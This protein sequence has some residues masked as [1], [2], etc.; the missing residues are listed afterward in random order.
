MLH[1]IQDAVKQ[2]L[3]S[4]K[5]TS[6]NGW[7]SFNAV[8]C[9]HTGES[10]DTRSRGGLVANAD[11]GVSYH[12]FNCHYKA[13]YTPG[14]HLNFKFR[15]LLQWLG[16][17]DNEVKR[18]V[19][20]ALRIKDFVAPEKV[21]E[22]K[23]EVTFKKRPLPDNSVS[24]REWETFIRLQA[25]DDLLNQQFLSTFNYV[26]DRKIDFGKYDFYTTENE[27]Y[28]LHK[29][30]II[31]FIWQGDIIGYT[32]RAW[33]DK[34]SPKYHNSYE[35]NFVFNTNNQLV[36]SKFVLVTEGPFDAMSVDGVAI[37]GS[38]CSETQADIIESL[39][40]EVIVVPDFD[41]KEVRGK[42]VWAGETLVDKAI[43]YG[44]SVSFPV[45]SEQVKDTAAA[46]EA[47]GKLFTIKSILAGKQSSR[48]KIEL[49]KRRIHTS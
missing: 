7:I 9:Q 23:E 5:K 33:D 17:S 18:L 21:A 32:A 11:G 39:G 40:K 27:A 19:I 6:S 43:E 3:P 8:C 38:E 12:C 16:A 34:V 35:P 26:Y 37:L 1:T 31:P 14:R 28:N 22:V 25:E 36:T 47:Y 13:N 42:M 44:W 2:L 41:V 20:D 4:K 48:L 15:K 24:F 10:V 30:V 46:V 29:R 45:W 49:M